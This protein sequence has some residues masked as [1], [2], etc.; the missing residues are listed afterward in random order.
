MTD[1][2]PISGPAIANYNPI[3]TAAEAPSSTR[4]PGH[5]LPAP[6]QFQVN[7]GLLFAGING[8]PRGI[9]ATA[10]HNFAPRAG[11]AFRLTN[12][13]VLRGGYGWYYMPKGADRMSGQ[14]PA[15]QAVPSQIGFQEETSFQVQGDTI[16]P[17]LPN[18]FPNGLLQPTGSSLGLGTALGQTITFLPTRIVNPLVQ[19]AS[20]GFQQQLPKQIVMEVGYA[21]TF[22]RNLYTTRQLDALPDRYLSTT[23][24]R[25]VTNANNLGNLIT[26]P[27]LPTLGPN[28]SL[29]AA[30]LP[31]LD[32]L[33]PYPEFDGISYPQ[34][35]GS[36][37]YNGVYIRGEKRFSSG[38]SLRGNYTFSKWL[39]TTEYLNAGDAKPDHII[40]DEDI[41][42]KFALSG[43]YDIPVG[44]GRRYGNNLNKYVAAAIGGWETTMTWYGQS[45]TPIAFPDSIYIGN[46]HNITLPNSKKSVNE[47]FN[48]SSTFD[49]NGNLVSGWQT[50]Q[51]DQ[52]VYDLRT[53]PLRLPGVRTQ[54]Q[55]DAN[56]SLMKYFA[57]PHE[58]RLQI[59]CEGYNVFNHSQLGTPNTTEDSSTFGQIT[60][61]QS[62]ARQIFFVGKILF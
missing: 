2:N 1:P 37:N 29:S 24:S 42:Q 52:L 38:W 54:G 36:S 14:N 25:N 43:I 59:R 51:A 13:T 56:A 40:S 18:P 16:G 15:D 62:T 49:S 32:F 22:A 9:W 27:F 3:Y 23:G 10:K 8:N 19:R 58:S 7:G 34:D 44:R 30:T 50:N 39:Q 17:V 20:F 47:W 11:A 60:S 21:G 4:D 31:V 12:T 45:G 55:N 41:P 48:T 53:F 26:N 6:A 46:Y 35:N 5:L 57:L 28:T 61:V 33:V